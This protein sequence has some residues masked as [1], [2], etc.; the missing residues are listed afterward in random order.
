MGPNSQRTFEELFPLPDGVKLRTRK[1]GVTPP[2]PLVQ[3]P[4]PGQAADAGPGRP[5][6]KIRWEDSTLGL[7][8][9]A[10]E[11]AATGRLIG[12][13][14][15]SDPAMLNKASVS[16]ALVGKHEHRMIRKT[17]K[18]DQPD[19]RTGGCRGS[20]DFGSLDN[21]IKELGAEMGLVVFVLL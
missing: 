13:V 1:F 21:A 7:T 19:N 10:R 18:L 20:D 9:L 15:C 12:E 11:D 14:F 5:T 2:T 16:V 6:L 17:V 4:V 8:V 3:V